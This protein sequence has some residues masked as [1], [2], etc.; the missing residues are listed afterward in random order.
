MWW[1]FEV[2]EMHIYC[3]IQPNNCH[4]YDGLIFATL[5]SAV[6][7]SAEWRHQDAYRVFCASRQSKVM[8]NWWKN[9]PF[10]CKHS[11]HKWATEYMG[12][13]TSTNNITS[14]NQ[15][16]RVSTHLHCNEPLR[17]QWVISLPLSTHTH[18]IY[19]LKHRKSTELDLR[20]YIFP[21]KH[22]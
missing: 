8:T 13:M 16:T 15:H 21:T 18:M 10:W 9:G 12:S 5:K 1:A 7:G 4:C 6:C 2:N 17:Q 14:Q 19:M 22:S 20:F 11:L 3:T